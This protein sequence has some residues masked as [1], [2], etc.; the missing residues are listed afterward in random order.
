MNLQR[1][2]KAEFNIIR[3]FYWDLIDEM[4]DLNEK[5]GWKKGIY[6][7][8]HFLTESLEMGE[9]FTMSEDKKLCACVIMNCLC[10]EGYQ[11]VP[12]SMECRKEE[13]LIPHALAVA[14]ECQGMGVGRKIVEEIIKYAQVAGKKAIRL[15]ILGTNTVAEKLY[16][17]CGFQFV[18][19]KNMYYEDTGWTEYKMYELNLDPCRCSE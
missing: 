8:D 1:A 14:P 10:N 17:K 18:Q 12:W 15:D 4:K 5:I 3:E 7:T 6:P 13:V 19:A 16:T 2:D 11:G 9:L